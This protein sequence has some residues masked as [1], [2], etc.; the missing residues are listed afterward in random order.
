MALRA[1]LAVVLALALLACSLPALDS[2]RTERTAGALDAATDRLRST[3]ERLVATSDPTTSGPAAR[4]T[5]VLDLPTRGWGARSGSVRLRDGELAWRVAGGPWHTD[6]APRLVVPEGP[7]VLD[8][9]TRLSLTHRLRD[10]RSVVVVRR[11]FK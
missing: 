3:G 5:L 11:G 8:G 10:G 9:P 7:L 4:R 2:A 1:V 6:R